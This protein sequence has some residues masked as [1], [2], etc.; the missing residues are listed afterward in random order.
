MSRRWKSS[1]LSCKVRWAPAIHRNIHGEKDDHTL[2]ESVWKWRIRNAKEIPTKDFDKLTEEVKDEQGNVKENE[3]L[4]AFNDA[5]ERKLDELGCPRDSDAVD[6]VSLYQFMN[7]AIAYAID[8]VL[9]DVQRTRGVKRETSQRTKDL[10]A[11]RPKMKGCTQGQFDEHQEKIKESTLR[12]FKEWVE[13]HSE[14][15]KSAN[16]Q[17]DTRSIY[18]SVQTL[19]QGQQKSPKNL[20][21]DGQGSMLKSLRVYKK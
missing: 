4:T 16:G 2:L 21:T 19:S 1:V 18:K 14:K 15:M 5:V 6:A 10:Y 7:E 12:D 13:K 3:T 9:P 8:T 17:G 11:K 20:T